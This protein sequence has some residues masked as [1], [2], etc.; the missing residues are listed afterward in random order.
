LWVAERLALMVPLLPLP[1]LTPRL[2]RWGRAGLVAAL[3][4]VAA[5]NA[6]Y[7]T[8]QERDA[9][10]RVDAFVR[11][12]RAVPPK[13]TLLALNGEQWTGRARLPLL[14]HVSGYVAAER[15]LADLDNYEAFAGYFP[16]K[17]RRGRPAL[18]WVSVENDPSSFDPT[19][20]STAD[21]VFAWHLADD[22][23][24]LRRLASHYELVGSSP[25]ARVYRRREGREAAYQIL[26]PIAGTTHPIDGASERWNVEQT[27]TNRGSRPFDVHLSAC[28]GV[29]CDFVL[30]AGTSRRIA[31]E[32]DRPF[33]IA[34]VPLVN[35]HDVIVRTLV[36]RD[37][38]DGAHS[39]LAV[40][41]MP[42]ESF[43][44]RAIDIP[45]VP[46]SGRVRLR[47]WVFGQAPPQLDLIARAQDG[48]E[49]KRV[50]I[51]R[52]GDGYFSGDLTRLFAPLQGDCVHLRVEVGDGDVWGFVSET[53]QGDDPDVLYLPRKA[54]G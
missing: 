12:E 44:R 17:L 30:G 46:L 32:P 24:S 19:T 40:P 13:T 41:S 52:P 42:L 10:R 53:G 5:G 2:P 50:T 8:K 51:A 6:L 31:S 16:V 14:A 23:P 27:I 33:I 43:A 7:L 11:A 21:Y 45:C 49:L 18:D 15:R 35:A 37:G 29:P 28:A 39:L 34:S 48:K 22:A 47:V 38:H 54:G 1:W 4:L 36:E 20:F 3:A 26:L 9:G 25:E